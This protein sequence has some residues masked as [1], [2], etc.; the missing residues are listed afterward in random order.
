MRDVN[1]DRELIAALNEDKDALLG[2]LNAA[3]SVLAA[4]AAR[5]D[6][7]TVDDT[8]LASADP[9]R[10]RQEHLGS[11]TRFWLADEDAA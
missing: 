7:L 6:G 4:L 5:P 9:L 8:E 3:R 1:Y 2:R 11:E 10:L